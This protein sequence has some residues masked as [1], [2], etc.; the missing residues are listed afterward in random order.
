MP[1]GPHRLSVI[2]LGPP[3]L[4]LNG[5][6]LE[7]LRRK[8]RALVYYLAAHDKPLTRDHL[9]AF[10]WP[11]HERAAGQQ[12]L[13]TMLHDLR[14][15]LGESLHADDEMLALAPDTFVDSRTFST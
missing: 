1:Q 7:R 11:D 6:R 14:K 2:L 10:F 4:L 8:N 5:Q 3:Q 12:T 9:L 15:H 13:R